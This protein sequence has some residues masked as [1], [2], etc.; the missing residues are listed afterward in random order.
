ME[1]RKYGS[2]NDISLSKVS[3]PSSAYVVQDP[4]TDVYFFF[5]VD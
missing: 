1:S 2:S 3:K 5:S 4:E